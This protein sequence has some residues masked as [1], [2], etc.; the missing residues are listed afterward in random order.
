MDRWKIIV[1]MIMS[2]L[3]FSII[4]GYIFDT[5]IYNTKITSSLSGLERLP[6]IEYEVKQTIASITPSEEIPTFKVERK[7]TESL[8]EII[9]TYAEQGRLISYTASVSL[10]VPRNEVKNSV[11]KALA[12]MDV[13]DGYISSMDV[14]EKTAYLV[15]K[16]PQNNLFNFLEDVLKIGEAA[17]RSISGI[18]VTDQII[19]LRARI[20]NAE[21]TEARLLELLNQARNISETLEVMRELSKVREEIEVMKAQLRNLEINV[22]YSTVAIEISEKELEKEKVELLFKVIDSRDL[23]VPNTYIYVKDDSVRR[24]VTDEFGEVKVSFE[25]NSNITLIA[26]FYR[27]DG[28][29]LKTS[30]TEV[31]DSNKTITIKFNKSSEPPSINL[32]KLPIIALGLINFLITGLTIIILLVMPM[33]LLLIF[34]ITLA[35]RAYSRMKLVKIVK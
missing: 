32:E 33:L 4:S 27:S 10:L 22:S 3:V 19:D 8:Q 24:F 16:I 25:K 26:V 14:G 1:V 5:L 13:Y 11:D 20:R 12:I 23:L 34:L 29:I 30:L 9:T 28:E 17:T 7:V 18:D 31:A 21:A 2:V 6:S 35:R 15:L